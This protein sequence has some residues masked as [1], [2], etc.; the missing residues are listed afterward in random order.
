MLRTAGYGTYMAGKWH[1]ANSDPSTWPTPA[2]LRSLLRLPGGDVGVFPPR[3]T[4]GAAPRES[5]R[6][7]ER[8]YT[9][10]AFTDEAIGYLREHAAQ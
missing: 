3:P 10:D 9:T 2:R 5:S 4:S 7:G 8:Y 6:E 1:I